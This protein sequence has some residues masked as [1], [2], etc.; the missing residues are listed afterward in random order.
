M[1]EKISTVG[2]LREYLEDHDDET[3]VRVS[4]GGS[5]FLPSPALKDDTVVL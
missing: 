3:H 2:E 1:S 4:D 5:L